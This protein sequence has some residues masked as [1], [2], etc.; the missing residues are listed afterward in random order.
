MADCT[1]EGA[2]AWGITA[3]IH[4][5]PDYRKT[6]DWAEAFARAGF[7]GIL[8][9]LRHD[10][11]QHLIGV[12]LFGPPEDTTTELPAAA[13]QPI[14]KDLLQQVTDRFGILIKSTS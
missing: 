5:S 1:A 6:Q 7:D 9:Y 4:S 8:Y 14:G 2:R 12:A 3:E 10:P 13:S 11:A